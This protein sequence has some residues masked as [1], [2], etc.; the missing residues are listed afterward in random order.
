MFVNVDVLQAVLSDVGIH[1]CPQK[2][3]VI[4]VFFADPIVVL[5]GPLEVEES[6]IGESHGLGLTSAKSFGG[7][8][9]GFLPIEVDSFHVVND[10]LDD[11]SVVSLLGRVE[12]GPFRVV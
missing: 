10:L 7:K 1:F 6:F 4:F 3:D 5:F 12:R 9:N 8:L 11:V 2:L